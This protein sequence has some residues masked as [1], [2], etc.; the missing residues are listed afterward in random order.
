MKKVRSH[1]NNRG[2]SIVEILVAISVFS[3]FVLAI[4]DITVSSSRQVNYSLN[5]ERATALA[6]EG[7]EATRNIRD[8]D[9]ANLSDG[10]YGVTT[11]GN[12]FNLSGTSDIT[13]FF[14]RTIE[15]ST[16]DEEQKQVVA[17]VA[18]SDQIL[19]TNSVT[20]STYLTDWR[21]I[22][23][24]TCTDEQSFLEVDTSGTVLTN[25][26]R[27]LEGITIGSTATDCD[28]VITNISLTWTSNRRL[29]EI[30]IDGNSVWTGNVTSGTTNDI[31][32]FTLLPGQSG[33]GTVY[34][35]NNSVSGNTFSITYTMSDG[36]TKTASDIAP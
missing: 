15:I 36:T 5:M 10:T 21:K 25:S 26:N 28:I 17:I 23:Q 1:I 18:W 31:T 3:V 32:D 14:N 33:V 4:S 19:P 7:L 27:R 8:A 29:Q 30:S 2:F 9:F 11:L 12:Q 20:L 16:V 34:R 22:T 24:T 13:D 6:E 35:F